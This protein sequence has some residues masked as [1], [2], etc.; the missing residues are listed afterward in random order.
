M[1]LPAGGI[2]EHDLTFKSPLLLLPRHEHQHV[3]CSELQLE[4]QLD[5]ARAADLIQGIETP[6]WP[7]LPG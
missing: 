2:P 6:L 7:P 4:R 1:R 3:R 5:R